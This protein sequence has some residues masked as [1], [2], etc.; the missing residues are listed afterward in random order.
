MSFE[1]LAEL[2]VKCLNTGESQPIPEDV[3]AGMKVELRESIS[4][5]ACA[6]MGPVGDCPCIRRQKSLPV[7]IP[8]THISETL[9]NLLTDEEKNTVNEI[10]RR[11]LGRYFAK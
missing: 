5:N 4:A 10:K 11:A 8:E 7:D 6:C 1:K 3:L 2:T 9:W